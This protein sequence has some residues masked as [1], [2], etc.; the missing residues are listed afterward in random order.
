MPLPPPPYFEQDVPTTF[1]TDG[2]GLLEDPLSLEYV[3][4]D[5]STAARMA[6]PVQVFPASGRAVAEKLA[7]GYYR[8]PYAPASDELRGRRVV[9]WYCTLRVGEPERRWTTPW[10]VLSTRVES[11]GPLYALVSDLRDEGFSVTDLSDMRAQLL[12]ARATDIITSITRRTFVPVPKLLTI[13][14]Y[15]RRRVLLP[16]ELVA[17]DEVYEGRDGDVV[18]RSC[19]VI[20]NRHLTQRL[21]SPDDRNSPKLELDGDSF[22]G[23]RRSHHVM[24]VWGYTDPDGSPMGKTPD[25]VRRAAMLLVQR[26]SEPMGGGGRD[27]SALQRRITMERTGQQ[28]V[29][30]STPTAA[31]QGTPMQ[32]A[33]TGDPDIDMLLASLIKPAA[34]G[35]A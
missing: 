5:I 21:F 26:E 19:L 8:A 29:M 32:G 23:R 34:M 25:R 28:T 6:A 15:N 22:M 24:G 12:L 3:V 11:L 2:G 18:T 9:R 7:R 4:L 14:G 16:E 35:A 1:V 33:F 20:Y 13:D 17:L 30:Y 31:L 10:E 27:D